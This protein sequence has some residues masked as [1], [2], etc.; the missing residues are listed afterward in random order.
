M[1]PK[2]KKV[3]EKD[4]EA[5]DYDDI[6]INSPLDGRYVVFGLFVLV[7]SLPV[8]IFVEN[9]TIKIIC[10]ICFFASF[11]IMTKKKNKDLF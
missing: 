4:D 3:M 5:E 6:A 2:D 8:A 1:E 9:Q 10:G 7:I 11:F